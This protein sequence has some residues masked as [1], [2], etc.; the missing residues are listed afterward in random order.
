MIEYDG[1]PDGD[2]LQ[3]GHAAPQLRVIV[4]A[5]IWLLMAGA[6]RSSVLWNGC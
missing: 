4:Y 1:Q 2:I 5:A 3:V 6:I